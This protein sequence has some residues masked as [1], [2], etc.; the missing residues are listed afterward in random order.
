MR[1]CPKLASKPAASSSP[2]PRETRPAA[3]LLEDA[4]SATLSAHARSW[5]RRRA[6]ASDA[7]PPDI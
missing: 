4:R 5:G 7:R 1:P 3:A 6:A 2:P